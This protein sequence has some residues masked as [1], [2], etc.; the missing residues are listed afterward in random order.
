M[1]KLYFWLLIFLVIFSFCFGVSFSIFRWLMNDLPPVAALEK[2]KTP[3]ISKDYDI[4][5]DVI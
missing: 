3:T 4:N 2:V 1:K 5:G